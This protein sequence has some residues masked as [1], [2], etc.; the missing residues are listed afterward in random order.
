MIPTGGRASAVISQVG[1]VLLSS[2]SNFGSKVISARSSYSTLPSCPRLRNAAFYR[3]YPWSGK[4]S[5]AQ[6]QLGLFFTTTE[7]MLQSLCSAFLCKRSHCGEKP[8]YRN[9]KVAPTGRN[10]RKPSCSN[11]ESALAKINKQNKMKKKFRNS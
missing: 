7:P 2:G 5:Y 6:G 3:F 10:Q 4:I 9:Q 1:S 11:E 8:T